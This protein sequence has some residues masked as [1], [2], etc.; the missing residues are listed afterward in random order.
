[1]TGNPSGNVL[2]AFSVEHSLMSIVEVLILT[3]PI[4]FV[5]ACLLIPFSDEI[6]EHP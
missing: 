2:Q 6:H 1:M 3:L 5:V 4:L